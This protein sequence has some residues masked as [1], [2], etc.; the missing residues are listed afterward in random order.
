MRMRYTP[1]TPRQWAVFAAVLLLIVALT[2]AL[3][4]GNDR[5]L[6]IGSISNK[7]GR[8]WSDRHYFLSGTMTHTLSPDDGSLHVEVETKSGA[9]SIEMTDETGGSIFHT[10]E[11]GTEA[12]DVDVSGSV[13]VRIEA[14]GHRGS[15]SIQ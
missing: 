15:F 10:D 7:T 9:I 8:G 11:A 2:T 1:K 6:K 12:F 13:T 3:D 4:I 5:T 14:D